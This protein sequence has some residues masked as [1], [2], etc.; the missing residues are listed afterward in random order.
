[1][2]NEIQPK[3]KSASKNSANLH[4]CQYCRKKFLKK[5]EL[6]VIVFEPFFSLFCDWPSFVF[7][8][9]LRTHL[10]KNHPKS[11]P[12]V[13]LKRKYALWVSLIGIRLSLVWLKAR[14][15]R[16]QPKPRKKKQR[17]TQN[18]ICWKSIYS[19]T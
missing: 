11:S 5:I 9:H 6:K 4:K 16:E 15:I 14:A 1:M 17:N 8:N 10:E 19:K 13:L 7:K 2:D 12:N 18:Q 3:S